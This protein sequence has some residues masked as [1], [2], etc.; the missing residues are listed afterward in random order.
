MGKVTGSDT[1][2]ILEPPAIE[3]ADPKYVSQRFQWIPSDFS[4]GNNGKVTLASPYINNI[5]P[6]RHGELLYRHDLWRPS[7]ATW[8]ALVIVSQATINWGH[9]TQATG[10]TGTVGG[11]V[12]GSNCLLVL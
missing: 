4:V 7:H 11:I 3:D 5:H 9:G 10:I 1:A 2:T 8:R 12:T 6:T